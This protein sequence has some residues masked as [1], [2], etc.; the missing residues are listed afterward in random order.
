MEFTVSLAAARVNAGL[1]QSEVAEKLHVS[2]RT[3]ICWEN[4]ETMPSFA[5]LDTLSRL[6]DVPMDRIR[7]PQKST[8]S[9]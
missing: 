3:V 9:E 6:Y 2:R 1:K 8:L 5:T 7:L 4:G